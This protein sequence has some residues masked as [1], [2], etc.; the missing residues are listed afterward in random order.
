MK[1]FPNPAEDFVEFQVPGSILLTA[2]QIGSEI[3]V[4]SVMGEEVA[5]ILVKTERV[6]WDCR[7]AKEGIYFYSLKVDER[8][9]NGKIIV[10]R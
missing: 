9:I 5:K 4:L 1:V 10:L 7:Y 2:G 8:W 3:R 6:V